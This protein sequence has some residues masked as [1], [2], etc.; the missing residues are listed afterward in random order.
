M[1]C[2]A[3]TSAS[4]AATTGSRTVFSA[5]LGL[6]FL[7]PGF[8]EVVASVC[9]S[10]TVTASGMGAS[11]LAVAGFA[12]FMPLPL[13]AFSAGWEASACAGVAGWSAG[14]LPF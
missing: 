6:F 7:A 14:F 13:M 8:L 10:L 11:E 9:S 5:I 3:S 2:G 4:G 1:A 12:F